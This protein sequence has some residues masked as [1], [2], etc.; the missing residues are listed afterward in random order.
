MTTDKL[1]GR[2]FAIGMAAYVVI[3]FASI[4]FLKAHMD[5]PWRFP[6]AV[7]PMLPL[8][9]VARAN[10]RWLGSLDELQKRIQYTALSVTVLATALIVLTYGFLENAGLPNVNV[11][12]VW[13]LMGFIWGISAMFASRYYR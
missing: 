8:I 12:W 2:E 13:P 5:S 11:M 9:Y 1:Y 3:L 7:L 4:Y 6:V 10:V